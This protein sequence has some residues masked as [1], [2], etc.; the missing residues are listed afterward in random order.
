M[1]FINTLYN[2][3]LLNLDREL[4]VLYFVGTTTFKAKLKC[5]LFTKLVV[6]KVILKIQ[7]R[8][9]AIIK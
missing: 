7:I 2:K 3:I 1:Y 9:S 8:S 6:L 5:I 4:V